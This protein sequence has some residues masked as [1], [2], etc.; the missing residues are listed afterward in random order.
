MDGLRYK[1]LIKGISLLQLQIDFESL[2]VYLSQTTNG[3]VPT[4]YLID[5]L[6]VAKEVHEPAT[7]GSGAA[8]ACTTTALHGRAV[9]DPRSP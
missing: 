2:R 4:N 5:K 3:K 9:L 1:R 8:S 6:I 7:A